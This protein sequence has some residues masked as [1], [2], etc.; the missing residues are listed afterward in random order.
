VFLVCSV[1]LVSGGYTIYW[2]QADFLDEL[3]PGW[4]NE[5]FASVQFVTTNYPTSFTSTNGYWLAT[6]TVVNSGGST[7]GFS[8]SPCQGNGYQFFQPLDVA[9]LVSILFTYSNPLPTAVGGVAFVGGQD[10]DVFASSITISINGTAESWTYSTTANQSVFWG[11][12]SDEPIA[13]VTFSGTSINSF[14]TVGDWVTGATKASSITADP[15][16]IGI[17]GESY[18]VQGEKNKWFNAVSSPKFQYN[19][20]FSAACD[21]KGDLTAITAVALKVNGQRILIN[22]TGA[23]T[24]NG[25]PIPRDRWK[26]N[27]IG[28]NGIYGTI[29][30]PWENNFYIDTP[31]FS[32]SFERHVV[33]FGIQKPGMIFYGTNCVP[34]YFNMEFKYKN[35]AID[36]HGLLGQTAHHN[37]MEN[38]IHKEEGEGEIEGTYKDYIVS[39]PFED[40]FKFN[41]YTTA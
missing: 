10:C 17:Q 6:D 25:V 35:H 4:F 8:I 21:N 40:D 29:S 22:D 12:T 15:H 5:T 33:D 20:F 13:T 37:H 27:P 26:S 18:Q 7:P 28:P 32:L 16:F 24:L 38:K 19:M 14:L 34:S 36:M 2:D 1:A 11:I 9:L 23:P 41:K 3:Q 30:R 31:D 39:G